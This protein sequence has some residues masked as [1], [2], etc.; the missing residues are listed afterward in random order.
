MNDVPHENPLDPF[1]TKNLI[2]IDGTV[3]TFYPPRRP[4]ANAVVTLQPGNS[5]IFSNQDGSFLFTGLISDD[6][7]VYATAEGYNR[8]SIEVTLNDNQSSLVFNLDGLPYFKNI[9]LKTHHISRHFPIDEMYSLQIDASV[10]DFDGI[11]DINQVAFAIP[12]LNQTGTLEATQ[13][14]GIF[15][16]ILN[17][18]EPVPSIHALIGRQFILN[19]TDDV[20]ITVSSDAQ[21]LTRVIDLTPQLVFP[22]ELDT[23]TATQS[24]FEWTRVHLNYPFTLKIE[25]YRINFGALIKAKEYTNIPAEQRSAPIDYEFSSGNYLWILTIIDEFGNTSS[26]KEGTFH[27]Q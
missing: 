11:A 2:S 12:A 20:G 3:Q 7:T 27:V 19:V 14:F 22:T 5:R 17:I 21:F 13:N 6:Y 1:N 10:D 8:D 9:A 15:S 23:I 24:T 4:I 18:E 25:I 16:K 26:S